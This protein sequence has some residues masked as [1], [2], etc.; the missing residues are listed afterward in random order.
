MCV[1]DLHDRDEPASVCAVGICRALGGHFEQ[2]LNW[3]VHKL[4]RK[5]A[6]HA[7]VGVE[8]F[9]QLVG[10]AGAIT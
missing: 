3:H 7:R 4:A 1:T 5:R 6:K 2:S 8:N 9:L 10:F